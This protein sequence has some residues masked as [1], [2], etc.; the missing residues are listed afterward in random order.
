V[1]RPAVPYESEFL[2]I[3]ESTRIEAPVFILTAGIVSE[4][5]NK[6]EYYKVGSG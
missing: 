3:P 1:G 5:E 6:Y 2:T 4:I